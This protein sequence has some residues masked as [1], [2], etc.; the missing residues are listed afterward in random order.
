MSHVCQAY[1]SAQPYFA[2][3]PASWLNATTAYNRL[4]VAQQLL[5]QSNLALDLAQTRYKIGP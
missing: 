2:G 1:G 5:Q 4:S 3:C